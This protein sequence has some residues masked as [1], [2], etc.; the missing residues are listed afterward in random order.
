MALLSTSP[1]WT[2]MGSRRSSLG[3]SAA[4]CTLGLNGKRS[5][6]RG[7]LAPKGEG[8]GSL[9]PKGETGDELARK[10]LAAGERGA[11]K[12]ESAALHISF[13]TRFWGLE[14]SELHISRYTCTRVGHSVS[15]WV[16]CV[17]LP[18]ED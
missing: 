16:G 4:A 7:R 14:F 10:G 3:L 13:N 8:H 12:G 6:A 5:L 17:A 11:L 1:L 15:D 9:D 18:C 2:K